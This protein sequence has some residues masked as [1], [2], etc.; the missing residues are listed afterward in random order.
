MVT[1]TPGTKEDLFCSNR[2]VCDTSVGVCSCNTN[3]FTSNGYGLAG[4]RGDCGHAT[5]V[6]QVCPGTPPCSGHGECVGNPTYNCL[7]SAGWTGSDCS[8]R[9]VDVNTVT[10]LVVLLI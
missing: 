9:L 1:Q 4:Q 7:C 2:G 6:I 8:Q 5:A 3:Y 10:P